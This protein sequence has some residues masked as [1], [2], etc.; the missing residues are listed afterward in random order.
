VKAIDVQ[1]LLNESMGP[2]LDPRIEAT[3][4]KFG[5]SRIPEP[6][7]N[8]P[9]NMATAVGFLTP[10]GGTLVVDEHNGFY[11]IGAVNPRLGIITGRPTGYE[12]LDEFL[13]DL[14]NW[15]TARGFVEGDPT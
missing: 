4:N 13:E 11:S 6:V 1:C 2:S 15:L 12:S 9:T 7:P 14:P 5:V 8:L 10:K 3:L